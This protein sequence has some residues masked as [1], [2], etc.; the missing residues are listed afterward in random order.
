MPISKSRIYSIVFSWSK[1][2][3]KRINI[4]FTL[5]VFALLL[6]GYQSWL[7][8]NIIIFCIVIYLILRPVSNQI[9]TGVLALLLF[10]TALLFIF[11]KINLANEFAIIIFYDLCLCLLTIIF[12]LSNRNI[13][14]R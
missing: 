6:G 13:R 7:L 5:T 4:D 11:K 10:V 1:Y 9:M 8:A 12:Q 3:K 2:V 14:L